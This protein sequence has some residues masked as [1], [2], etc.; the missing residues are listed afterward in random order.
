MSGFEI[1]GVIAGLDGALQGG[2]K[3]YKVIQDVVKA[4]DER[5]EIDNLL[6]RPG[7]LM[8]QLNDCKSL[9]E[10]AK[11]A[12]KVDKLMFDRFLEL[13]DKKFF[14][15]MT[16]TMNRLEEKLRRDDGHYRHIK[17]L[18]WSKSKADIRKFIDNLKTWREDL[19]WAL[20]WDHRA[21]TRDIHKIVQ[22]RHGSEEL[23]LML[24]KSEQDHQEEKR[25]KMVE[26]ILNWLSP[27][28]FDAKHSELLNIENR[29]DLTHIVVDSI[30]FQAW[31][32]GKHFVLSCHADAGAGKVR[33][34]YAVGYTS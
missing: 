11:K 15:G 22:E 26:K 4:N 6:H 23:V 16:E 21:T 2:S 19:A 9:L 14:E 1:F 25:A 31:R 7:G 8:K 32:D 5:Q 10:D 27:L 3:L 18:I 20:D 12:E 30:E 13:D 34:F 24:Q 33:V 28:D 29:I 17:R